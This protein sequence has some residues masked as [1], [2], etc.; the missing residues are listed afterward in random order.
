MSVRPLP[1]PRRNAAEYGAAVQIPV[2]HL[3]KFLGIVANYAKTETYSGT[4]TPEPQPFFP[5]LVRRHIKAARQQGAVDQTDEIV[6]RDI[7][8]HLPQTKSDP[9]TVDFVEAR[10]LEGHVLAAQID[11]NDKLEQERHAARQQL[12][13]LAGVK[14]II[15]PTKNEACLA[16]GRFKGNVP[17]EVIDPV[18]AQT[19]YLLNGFCFTLAAVAHGYPLRKT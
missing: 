14:L 6:A 18:L 8:N 16:L 19:N 11:T 17:D 10:L 5:L 1:F 9:L 15:P 13:E 3:L 7:Y 4:F 2:D 12:I